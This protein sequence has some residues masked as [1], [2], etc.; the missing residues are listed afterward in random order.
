M[1]KGEEIR[2]E[3]IALRHKHRDRTGLFED[4][5]GLA[6]LLKWIEAMSKDSDRQLVED[7]LI[8]AL[9]PEY[10]KNPAIW[11]EAGFEALTACIAMQSIRQLKGLPVL[12]YTL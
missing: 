4:N 2:N 7:L 12:R 11:L 6:K 5:E 3:L 8:T 1:S 9:T 10:K